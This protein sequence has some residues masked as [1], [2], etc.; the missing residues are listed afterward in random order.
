MKYCMKEGESLQCTSATVVVL[1]ESGGA[2]EDA[3]SLGNG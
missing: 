1:C 3:G 2:Q